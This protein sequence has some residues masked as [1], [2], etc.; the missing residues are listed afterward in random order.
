MIRTYQIRGSE[1]PAIPSLNPSPDLT[2]TSH[3]RILP[4]S[5]RAAGVGEISAAGDEVVRVELE[6]GFALGAC[7]RPHPPYQNG[8]V[9]RLFRW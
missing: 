4:G 3:R 1:Q 7:R 6:H 9:H 5:A 2:I 8:G